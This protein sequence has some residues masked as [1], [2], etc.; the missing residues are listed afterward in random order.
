[1]G[2]LQENGIKVPKYKVA[3]SANEVKEIA[4]TGGWLLFKKKTQ[5]IL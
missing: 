3:S 2:V 4:K 5:L 1:M